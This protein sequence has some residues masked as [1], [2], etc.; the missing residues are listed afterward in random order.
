VIENNL[1]QSATPDV[2]VA[3]PDVTLRLDSD[4]IIRKA[5]LS[6]NLAAG[7]VED[8]VGRPWVETVTD[9]GDEKVKRMLE[10]AKSGGVSAFRQFTQCFPNGLELPMEYTTV[11]LGEGG[12]LLAVGKSLQAVAE[13]QSRLVTAQQAMER[14]YWKL[15]Y[16]ET[17]YRLLL[18]AFNEPVLLVKASNLRIV[19]V[20]PSASR[21]LGIADRSG[22]AL[23]KIEL[24][25]L[26]EG[27]DRKTLE[28]MLVRVRDQGKSPAI[29]LHFGQSRKNW[30]VRASMVTSE[31][32]LVY[33]LQLTP[34]ATQKAEAEQPVEYQQLLQRVPDAF[35]AIDNTGRILWSNQAFLKMIQVSSEY[36]LEGQPI[37]RWLGRPGADIKVLLANI[38]LHDSVRLFATTIQGELGISSEV[39]ISAGSNGAGKTT[40]IGLVLRDVGSR[41]PAADHRT[42]R[43]LNSWLQDSTRLIGTSPLRKLVRDTVGVVERH[44]IE[45]AL[46]LTGGNRTAT[47]ELLGIS[48]QSLYAKM[49]RY[50]LG[51]GSDSAT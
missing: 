4:G 24:Y 7:N 13:L 28:S 14:D 45:V 2:D 30:Y 9:F 27:G 47:A 31:Q 48:R 26:I 29:L 20:S 17:R 50:G 15:R 25:D 35:V 22:S 38:A 51:T 21:E 34:A 16:L 44:Y 8:W 33:F 23:E 49:G 42:D 18:D 46:E 12:G 39:E 37:A 43:G 41:L 11:Q 5:T 32:G 19:E 1:M 36:Q 10:E 6:H 40:H 3:R